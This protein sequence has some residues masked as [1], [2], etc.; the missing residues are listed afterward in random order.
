MDMDIEALNKEVRARREPL[1]L[2]V[3]FVRS[4]GT[5]DEWS[6]RD[7][8]SADKFRTSLIRQGLEILP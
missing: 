8:A 2:N 5:H 7:K 1:G 6:M 3:R 4:D